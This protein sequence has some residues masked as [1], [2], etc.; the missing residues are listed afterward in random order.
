[1]VH[2]DGVS[3]NQM[4]V[5]EKMSIERTPFLLRSFPDDIFDQK[6]IMITSVLNVFDPSAYSIGIDQRSYF[7]NIGSTCFCV[8]VGLREFFSFQLETE[9]K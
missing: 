1:M 7:M 2:T 3:K 6:P 4:I 8:R 9:Y 5:N